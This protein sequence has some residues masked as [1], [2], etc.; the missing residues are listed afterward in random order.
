MKIRIA[1]QTGCLI[2]AA[3]F[4][5]SG[6]AQSIGMTQLA[7]NE[8]GPFQLSGAW[9]AAQSVMMHPEKSDAVKT[10]PVTDKAT[11]SLVGTSGA[12][13]TAALG[14]GD[15]I[16]K[17]DFMLSPGSSAAVKLPGGYDIRL[18]DS[19]LS[20]KTDANLCGSV[21]N[22]AP[23]QNVCKAPGLWQNLTVQ[24]K[25][26][27]K[28]SAAQIEKLTLNGTVVLE[29]AFLTGLPT[30]E[31]SLGLEVSSG[32]TAFRNVFYQLLNDARPLAL[33]QL[34][35]TLYKAGNDRPR[36]LLPEN[37]V[38]KDTTSVLT[39]EWGIGS[40][41][42]YLVYD[43]QIEAAQEADYLLELVYMA[44]AS[45][46]IDGKTVSPYKWND[47]LQ[48]YVP[49]NVHLTKG[50][51]PFKL[52]YHKLTWRRPALGIFVSAQ[53]VR[54]YPL[55]LLSSVPEPDPMPLMAVN[56]SGKAELIR[57]FIQ[58]GEE[59]KKRTHCLSVGT[60]ASVNYTLDLNRG[61]L[62]Q[63]WKGNFA[64][65]TEMWYDRGEPQ[66]LHPMGA[67]NTTQGQV[68][69]AILTDMNAA[70]PDS[71]NE[72]VYK[73]Y[74]LNA[75]GIPMVMYRHGA[76][77]IADELVPENGGLVR[78]VSG[79]VPNGYVRAVSGKNISALEKG[80]YEV[81]GQSYYV[82]IDPKSKPIVR[83]VNGRQELLLPLNGTVRY[84]LI[85]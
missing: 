51:H 5:F 75:A 1:L 49:V 81:N 59:K 74:R 34:T 3:G 39:R 73:G 61:S 78:T 67:A 72:L 2:L 48:N 77:E 13:A 42:F 21:G 12:K 26:A 66:I 68:D 14:L 79:S 30:P 80:L 37:I 70:W 63:F 40:N 33:R 45:L 4:L 27:T 82:R 60:P 36:A 52:Q 31:T 7:T 53:G 20:T 15:V 47:F 62:L 69:W 64:N 65:V 25:K 28:N 19:W 22:L 84:S 23:L 58:H 11:G 32:T 71:L 55:H 76:I 56:A 6:H 16:L 44:N 50:S 38:K 43:G 8:N 17:L 24:Y 18:N 46:E 9:K 10:T 35:Y 57:S 54:P 83:T 85:W 29:N 41:S